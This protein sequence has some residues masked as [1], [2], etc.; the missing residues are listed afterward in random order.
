MSSKVSQ[1]P[2]GG[3]IQATDQFLIA[4][5][6][7][8][9]SILGSQIGGGG[10]ALQGEAY[11]F[12]PVDATDYWIANN[13]PFSPNP[14]ASVHRIYFPR[15]GIL[16]SI[17]V[18]W[19]N[20]SGTAPSNESIDMQV[21]VSASYTTIGSAVADTSKQK[22]WTKTDL[23]VAVTTNDYID[24]KMLPVTWATNPTNVNIN[25]VAFIET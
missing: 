11:Q 15:A 13:M 22:K 2:D 5:A 4:R 9:K 23:A 7:Q 20:W 10:Y 24:V 25:W 16:T 18:S 6:G 14:F 12:D 1:Y 19:D 8:N 3:A 21:G 17:I